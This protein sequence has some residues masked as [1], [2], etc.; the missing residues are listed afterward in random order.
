MQRLFANVFAN[1]SCV[2]LATAS[3][4]YHCKSLRHLFVSRIMRSYRRRPVFN[5]SRSTN[6]HPTLSL[7]ICR[8]SY[9]QLQTSQ[10]YYRSTFL[11]LSLNKINFD[12]YITIYILKFNVFKYLFIS[13]SLHHIP[14]CTHVHFFL[15]PLHC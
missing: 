15:Y 4:R 3:I 8:L 5:F 14:L 1:T 13:C 11:I 6:T 9:A 10:Q 12:C 7:R 2:C